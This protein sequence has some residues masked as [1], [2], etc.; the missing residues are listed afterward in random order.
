MLKCT[1]KRIESKKDDSICN[2][3]A[4]MYKVTKLVS[5]TGAQYAVDPLSVVYM[6]LC[7]ECAK[8]VEKA[9]YNITIVLPS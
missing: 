7:P 3:P 4:K 8:R 6:Q 9:G 5:S 1:A 2:L